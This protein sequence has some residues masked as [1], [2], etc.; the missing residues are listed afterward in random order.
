MHR[1][2]RGPGRGTTAAKE[3]WWRWWRVVTLAEAT[4]FVAP[5]VVGA[6]LSAEP[7]AVLAIAL[8]AAGLVEGAALGAG[9]AVVLRRVLIDLPVRS[10][11]FATALAA[12]FAY[13]VAMVPVLLAADP[14]L[15][16]LWALVV[17]AAALSPV[18]LASIGTAQWLVLRRLVPGSAW[19]IPATAVAWLCGLAA[20]LAV[21]PP[22]WQ[23][24][25]PVALA[26]AI[27]G[28]GGLVMAA[29]VAALTGW[30]AVR[31]A[32]TV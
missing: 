32:R 4:G 19:W 3:L 21:A 17:L 2:A 16:P 18:L 8:V 25:Q 31:L 6:T 7:D 5:A 26:A 15:M 20:F 9:Q 1:R 12:G 23:D 22:L 27:G 24:G 10:F 29:V 14:S 30:A 13:A 28:L 11:V